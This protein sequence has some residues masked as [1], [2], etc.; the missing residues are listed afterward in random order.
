M[1]QLRSMW[2]R[3][4]L[5]KHL[6]T[7]KL[8]LQGAN[9]VLGYL[10]W[11]LEPL[12]LMLVYWLLIG[13][14]F[15]RGGNEYPLFIL[16]G[17]VPFRAVVMSLSQAVGSIASRYSIIRQVNFP[18][19][20]LPLSDVAAN[21]VKLA[22]GLVVVTGFAVK[23]G[24]FPGPQTLLLAIP[25]ALQCLLSMGL[26]LLMSIVGVYLRDMRNMM[27]FIVRIWL[28]LSP[29]LFPISRL[30]GA[31]QDLALLNPMAPIIIMYRDIIM[32]GIAP[33]PALIAVALAEIAFLAGTGWLVFMHYEARLLKAI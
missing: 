4:E 29:V 19:A 2:E 16:C 28:Y 12:L 20:F 5:F 6:V 32:S 21:Y 8:K 26:A 15:R 18:R 17:L 3:R 11:I 9:L 23:Y 1:K 31:W 24:H 33:D 30:P 25:F 14:V 13:V 27:Q 10:W 7:S 22:I